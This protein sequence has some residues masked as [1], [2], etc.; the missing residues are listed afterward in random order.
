MDERTRTRAYFYWKNKSGRAAG[1]PLSDWAEAVADE[2]FLGSL[3]GRQRWQHT[4]VDQNKLRD[5]TL[6]QP[7]KGPFLIPDVALAELFK[8]TSW[9]YV[10]ERSLKLL[11]QDPT[12]VDVAWSVGHVFR[13]EMASGELG[14]LVDSLATD[15]F[16]DFLLKVKAS[17]ARAF[18]E[19]S[20][21]IQSG[22][23]LAS[24]QHFDGPRN[25]QLVVNVREAWLQE[26]KP[27]EVRALRQ[28]GGFESDLARR[29]LSDD[30]MLKTIKLMLVNAGYQDGRANALAY[31]PSF[32][33]A[34]CLGLVA[35]AL[36]WIARG[37]LDATTSDAV[38]TNDIA[39]LD[40]VVFSLFC[41][42][43]ATTEKRMLTLRDVLCRAL[44][45][46]WT[47]NAEHLLIAH[48]ASVRQGTA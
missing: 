39:D 10:A 25:K 24:T 29:L 8:G 42:D 30:N 40:Y 32:T 46:L 2:A 44:G 22:R 23:H 6:L 31:F 26:L 33:G 18:N 37:G 34:H 45:S 4:V 7:S 19:Y 38:L 3:P 1:D 9:Q 12:S 21:R 16:R 43:Y 41:A 5:T 36:Q 28:P 14:D 35:L 27:D 20:T 47:R 15:A 13:Q 17:P 11:A 48:K